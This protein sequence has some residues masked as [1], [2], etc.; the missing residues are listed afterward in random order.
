MSNHTIIETQDLKKVY[1]SG[2]ASVT[3]LDGVSLKINSGEFVAIMGP[4]G[5]G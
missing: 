3:A 5:S 1:G 4:S 2:D